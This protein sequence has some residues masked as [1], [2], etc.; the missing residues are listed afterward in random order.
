VAQRLV[1]GRPQARGVATG[2]VLAVLGMD[3]AH[4][5]LWAL[6]EQ[7]AM[8]A[9]QRRSL[10]A[11]KAEAYDWIR[12][13]SALADRFIAY[14]DASLYLFTGRQ[15]MRPLAF[16]SEANY[17]NTDTVVARDLEHLAD[18]ARQIRAR[19]WLVTADDYQLEA[20]AAPAQQATQALV[21]QYPLLFRSRA[22]QVQ[23][24]RIA[25]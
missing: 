1:G 23:I 10:A 22:G 5:Y 3:A 17:R 15:V 21:R 18:T 25:D 4:S 8:A 9:A 20:G 12:T 11:E 2:V 24:Y 16:S 6:P 14:E 13:H 7:M 19:Y